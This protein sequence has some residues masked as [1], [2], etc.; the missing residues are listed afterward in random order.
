MF[1][2]RLEARGRSGSDLVNFLWK[3]DVRPLY[4]S[5]NHLTALWCW[6]REF[7][8]RAA[9]YTFVHIDTHWDAR[10]LW[11]NE[12]PQLEA[13]WSSL[14]SFADF[15]ALQG[16]SLACPT[17]MILF[18]NY[19]DP[20][21]RLY[22]NLDRAYVTAH[23]ERS[24]G[25]SGALSAAIA[26]HKGEVCSLATFFLHIDSYLAE[27]K[28]PVI[29]NIDIDYFFVSLDGVEG[30]TVCAFDPAF[31]RAFFS[32]LAR[33]WDR[34]GVMTI[35]LSPEYCDGWEP[36]EQVCRLA[37]DAL[38]VKYPLR[39]PRSAAYRGPDLFAQTVAPAPRART[40]V[41]PRGKR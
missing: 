35:A 22:P 37:F 7:P 32:I 8:D 4:L 11:D 18:D 24:Q 6:R 30:P 33:H 12:F 27:S 38:G 21:I 9:P 1:I 15:H 26:A 14:D 10:M 41:P 39:R 31:I 13:R 23:Q 20:F 28:S 2:Q 36:A 19:I 29:M 25:L 34:I 40:H 17:P 3:D 5:D 16:S